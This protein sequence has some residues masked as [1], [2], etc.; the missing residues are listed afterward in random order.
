MELRQNKNNGNIFHEGIVSITTLKNHKDDN[1]DG[2]W[3]NHD[4]HNNGDSCDIVGHSVVFLDGPSSS[5]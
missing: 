5:V 3:N 1:H 4:N 2:N